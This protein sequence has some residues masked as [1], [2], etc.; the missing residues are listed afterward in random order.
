[1]RLAGYLALA[2]LLVGLAWAKKKKPDEETQALLL[3]KDP[4]AAVMGETSRLVFRTTPLLN[5]GLLSAQTREAVRGLLRQNSGLET[6][7]IRA[8]VAGSGD[9]RRI[10]SIVSELFTEKKQPLPAVTV[11][12]AGGLPLENAQVVLESVSLAKH[13]VNAGGLVFVPAQTVELD[14]PLQP[15][16]P[17]AQ[18]AIARLKT[19]LGANTD[20]L[21]VTCFA[22]SLDTAAALTGLMNSAFP[23]AA[24]DLV[25]T[26]RE[27]LKSSFGCEAVARLTR[28]GPGGS[29]VTA[30]RLVFTGTQLAFGFQ[31]ADAV[32]ALQ[33]L[34]RLLSPFGSSLKRAVLINFFPLSS[35]VSEEIARV[36]PPFFDPAHLPGVTRVP[37]EGL[38]GI[39]SSFAA[40]AVAVV[41]Q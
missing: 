18:E 2:A 13:Q 36:A 28:E 39:D 32:L 34:D 9:L 15:L 5:K 27:P 14:R 41:N 11:V 19:A 8:F 25:Q 24:L 22:T 35:S 23:N 3:P 38:Q 20:I 21:R 7:K 6:I 37:F 40:E 12:L 31:D 4:P 1:M 29:A 26:Q 33:R 17:L 10:P 16:Q 30:P